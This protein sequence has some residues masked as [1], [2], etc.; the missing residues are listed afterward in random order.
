MDRN[1]KECGREDKGEGR[2]EGKAR[3]RKGEGGRKGSGGKDGKGKGRTG[4]GEVLKLDA[5]QQ[6][7]NRNLSPIST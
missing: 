2:E 7:A 6:Y 1:G 4:K 5:S 3:Q